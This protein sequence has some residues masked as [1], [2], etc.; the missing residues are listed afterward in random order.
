MTGTDKLAP[1]VIGSS[2]NPRCFRG[3][4]VPLPWYANKKA[5]M[6]VEI[7]REWMK[8]VDREMGRKRKKICLLLDNCTA[9]PH[10][11]N[12]RNIR[13]I[14]LPANTTS[15]IQ[16]LDQGTIRNF[17]A[18]YR[19]QLMQ[20]IVDDLDN[21]NIYSFYSITRVAL[22]WQPTGKR[23]RGRPKEMWRRTI[24]RDLKERGLTLD[25]ARIQL[26]IGPDG[27]PSCRLKNHWVQKR[28]EYSKDVGLMVDAVQ[29]MFDFYKDLG[30]DMFKDS[31]VPRSR[32]TITTRTSWGWSGI[33]THWDDV[34][35]RHKLAQQ[36]YCG[37][38]GGDPGTTSRRQVRD[39]GLNPGTLGHYATMTLLHSRTSVREKKNR[40]FR[41]RM[42]GEVLQDDRYDFLRHSGQLYV[43]DEDSDVEDKSVVWAVLDQNRKDRRL[44]CSIKER[45][46]MLTEFTGRRPRTGRAT[47]DY[48]LD[49]ARTEPG[50][51][52]GDVDD[53]DVEDRDVEDRDVEDQGGDVEDGDVRIRTTKAGTW[54]TGTWMTGTWRT[55]AGT[56][57]NRTGTRRSRTGT[58]RTCIQ[59]VVRSTS[60]TW[61]RAP[62]H[63]HLA[64]VQ[65]RGSPSTCPPQ[66]KGD[67]TNKQRRKFSSTS[68][69]TLELNDF[70]AASGSPWAELENIKGSEKFVD[71]FNDI[72]QRLAR[73]DHDDNDANDNGKPAD[74]GLDQSPKPTK[75]RK[76]NYKSRKS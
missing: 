25:T 14:F 48:T 53:R 51:Y 52:D 11:V 40:L 26:Q 31:S 62:S 63:H 72:R 21:G 39:S 29:K 70:V 43:Y 20:H 17:K 49:P 37:G 7:F 75:K 19:S 5:W 9:H 61:P 74:N 57:R 15:I 10:D 3:Q 8:K 24:Q 23:N 66:F 76:S 68:E 69:Y 60:S 34:A 54:R 41:L 71:R 35:W 47:E 73:E 50:A 55:K 28:I 30:I 46:R 2:K 56:W 38:G 1:L 33:P 42:A 18:L 22:T 27:N 13:L 6:T 58:W 67:M 12:L 59:K 32:P 64:A 45:K 4:R 65:V 16:P 36:A 44:S